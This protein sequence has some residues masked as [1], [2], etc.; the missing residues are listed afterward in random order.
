MP[1]RAA[2]VA[3]LTGKKRMTYD[4]GFKMQVVR[5]ALERP[6]DNRIK[7]TCA[8]Y[9]GIEPCQLRKWIRFFEPE[10]RIASSGP[11]RPAAPSKGSRNKPKPKPQPQPHTAR[12]VAGA[13]PDELCRRSTRVRK[14][15]TLLDDASEAGSETED[16][17]A[18]DE[19]TS[20]EL[21]DEDDDKS[22]EADEES[23][24][25]RTVESYE[26]YEG[27]S[28]MSAIGMPPATPELSSMMCGPMPSISPTPE[29]GRGQRGL[30]R[31]TVTPDKHVPIV[32]MHTKR[33]KVTP[34]AGIG[35]IDVSNATAG[36]DQP[37]PRLVTF[38]ELAGL[39][40]ASFPGALLPDAA[41][42][43]FGAPY[44]GQRPIPVPWAADETGD[45][46]PQQ[47]FAEWLSEIASD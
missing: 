33:Q 5:E 21:V 45:E 1:P 4:V 44:P 17:E 43:R 14:S 35:L 10:M 46:T 19:P 15:V 34:G 3:S 13:I 32:E 28:E 25:G 36:L 16:G 40:V 9:P 47:W 30:L 29:L 22:V 39:G 8:R 20:L 11:K 18:D 27:G 31:R 42:G 41:V 7:P 6:V 26:S 2:Q 23:M 37:S 12:D 24:S 38:S